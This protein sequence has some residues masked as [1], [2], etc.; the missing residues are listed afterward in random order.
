M[1]KKTTAI[2]F[3]MIILA[4]LSTACSSIKEETPQSGALTYADF[5]DAG[6]R[7]AVQT[8]DVYGSVATD[9]FKA[10]A[11]E[12]NSPADMLEVLRAGRIDAVLIDGS[13]VK[14]LTDSGSYPDVDFIWI[15]K[16]VFANESAHVFHTVELRDK[17]N[18]WLT[19][20][21]A[22]GTLDEIIGRWIGVPL[23]KDE[24]IP[25]FELTGENGTLTVCDTGNY[26]PFTYYDGSGQPVGFDYEMMSRFAQH[27]GMKLEITM[28][29]YDA[30]LPS[31][32]SGKAD[33]SACVYTITD[34]RD[35]SVIFGDPCIVSQGV[36]AV[37]NSNTA[38]LD[39][40]DFAGKDIAVITGVLTYTTTEKIGG[41]PI[42][43]NDSSASAEDVRLGRV[44]GYMH[45]LSAIRVMAAE[46]GNDTFETIA[47][48]KEIFSAQIGGISHDQAVIDSFNEFLDVITAD[49][50]LEDMQSRW[51]S[52]SLDLDASIPNIQNSGT[53][54][55]LKVAV[56]S[57]SVPYVYIGKNGEFSGFSV[58]LALRFGAYEGKTI[59]FTDMA[60]GGLIPYVVSQKADIG[61]ANMAITEERKQ[62]VLFT[63][64]FFDEQHGIL[65]LKQGGGTIGNKSILSY[66]DFIGKI[67]AMRTGTVW[68]SVVEK[69]L[70]STP[71]FYSD[72]SAGVED[73]RKGRVAGFITDLSAVRVFAAIPENQD[74]ICV[75]IPGEIFTAPMGAISR[76]QSIIDR[77]NVFLLGLK[78][79]GTLAN[80]QKRWLDTVPD[81]DS[82]MPDISLTGENGTLRVATCSGSMPFAYMGANNELKGY[83]I[84][85]VKRFAAYE[86]VNIEFAD[87]E[88]SGM[89]PYIVSGKAD[90]AIADISIT[91]ERKQ[92]V[93]FTG[94]IYDDRGGIIALKSGSV[95]AVTDGSD[96]IK[97]LKTGIERN[98]ITDN[99]WKMILN[100]LGVTITI[101]FMAQ[102]FGTLF[103]CF[104]CFVLTR[105]NRF[106]RWLGNLYCGLIHGTPI[107]VLLMITYYIIFGSTSVSNVLVAV[108]A[109]TFVMGAGVAGNLKA[110]IDT[111]DPVE[112]EAARS[113]GFSSFK[114]FVA[115]TFPQAVRRAL[116]GYTNG[117]VELVKATAIVGYIAIQDL[118][119]AGDIIR[120]RTYDA[121]FPLL[122]VAV[123][124]LIV[125]TICVQLFKL[126]VKKVNGGEAS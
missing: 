109:F 90:I 69:H 67:I 47:V 49:G 16:D 15:P 102:L 108:A 43:Y 79:D 4:S 78:S 124:Y 1:M 101:A 62:S 30:V 125:T 26:P 25:R 94:S 103:G 64:P 66:T 73:V 100:G 117:F 11:Q 60:F 113:I 2:L 6:K 41:R 44:A 34:E 71:A 86:G 120:S 46:L 5:I 76:D 98:L 115:V 22:D 56:C 55:V 32:I 36:L 82:P 17:Y 116:P 20:I 54:G 77:F 122:F 45:A 51:F 21:Q 118:T 50:T 28:M 75:E 110:A 72:I 39:Y 121:Y 58:E 61:L 9:V 123:I 111:I 18:E 95:F 107:V 24:D 81:L 53:N 3:I 97:W 37:L 104:V 52:E 48:P 19:E 7:F 33:M 68:D 87:M 112:I 84:E 12:Y 85:L 83:S 93:L 65:A 88:F 38:S 23:P 119:R 96:F 13:Y 99:R 80:I 59:E 27:L 29:S 31:I 91:E 106:V 14:P 8:G 57:D 10:Q 63:E 92:S 35:E 89:I 74:L 42:E 40:T 126:I 114:A 105:K 70:Q